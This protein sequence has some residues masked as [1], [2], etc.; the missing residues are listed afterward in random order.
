MSLFIPVSERQPR[1]QYTR[2]HK[3]FHGFGQIT[4]GIN[5]RIRSTEEENMQVPSPIRH[6]A[7]WSTLAIVRLQTTRVSQ[8]SSYFHDATTVPGDEI[9]SSSLAL[10]EKSF[11]KAEKSSKKSFHFF[12]TVLGGIR[13]VYFQFLTHTP[14][15]RPECGEGREGCR[16][17]KVESLVHQPQNFPQV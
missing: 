9:W 15:N 7:S 12:M 10:L 13:G 6:G 8:T 17:S 16:G 3:N 1:F 2:K 5:S 4:N 11:R 14:K